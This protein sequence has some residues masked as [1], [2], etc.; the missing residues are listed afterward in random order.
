MSSM[1][2]RLLGGLLGVVVPVFALTALLS[3]RA[4]LQEAGE[5]FD[6]KL[7]Q[8][9]RVLLSLVDEP[10]DDLSRLGPAGDAIVI[11]GWHGQAQGVGEA[12][13]FRTGHAYESKLAF[14]VRDR[15]GH[16][17]LR[18]DS[19]PTRQLAPLRAGFADV[20]LD[21]D[22]WRTF[23]LRSPGGRWFQTGEQA[24]I[25][26]E[27]AED[28]ALGTALPL[29]LALPV[30]VVLVWLVVSWAS[31]AL[32]RVSQA[33]GERD[34]QRL[35]PLP[36]QGVPREIL[37]LVAAVN[38]LMRRLQTALER[39][40]RF[41]A[42][43]AHEL[44][45]PIAALKVHADNLRQARDADERSESQRH[46]DA[47]VRRVERLVAQ[48]LTLSRVEPGAAAAALSPLALDA[49]VA[50][51]VEEARD[52]AARRGQHLHLRRNDPARLPANE[53]ALS[54]LVRNLIDNALR[55]APPQGQVEVALCAGR[56][57]V[58]FSVEDSGPGIPAEARERV[59]ARFHRELGS[60]VEG[61]GLGMAIVREV[62]TAHGGEVT[63]DASPTLGGLRVC[64]TLP[65]P[66]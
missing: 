22:R 20:T 13:A 48:L 63:L 19:G 47:S 45:T 34:P 36:L 53:A 33:I 35:E 61:S 17:L 62:V 12:L 23:S 40:R 66:P 39:E 57:G 49:L 46:L 27:L 21:G 51:Q 28:I 16:L 1:R 2:R 7:V 54:A 11:R 24:D 10:L 15:N 18:S 9:S 65:L 42:D 50:L 64:V 26:E 52:Q 56:D 58:C 14:Q 5:M 59:F 37:G 32:S 30:L 38:G 43:A 4:G 3:Y 8:S 29:L 25:R 60:G 41:I 55:Y 6:A 44:R 31:G